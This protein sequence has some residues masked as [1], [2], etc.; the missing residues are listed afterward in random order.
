MTLVF[1]VFK[2]GDGNGPN[3]FRV[4]KVDVSKLLKIYF[5]VGWPSSKKI[6]KTYKGNEL[7]LWDGK[8]IICQYSI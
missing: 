2:F 7:R 6:Y 1:K 3:L 4:N 8:K 5:G